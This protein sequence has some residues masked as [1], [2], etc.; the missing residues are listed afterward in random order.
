M[1]V[2]PSKVDWWLA[3][4]LALAPLISLGVGIFVLTFHRAG[5]YMAIGSS[6]FTALV[7]A[8][9]VFP[10]RYT[11]GETSLDI[12][13]GIVHRV[14]PYADIIGAE[15]SS[16]PLSAPALSLQRVKVTTQ[17]GFQLISPIDRAAFIEALNAKVKAAKV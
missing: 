14:I 6:V 17:K 4:C 13:C 16:N 1:D 3:A 9:L 8:L 12:R 5:G 10:C 11:L 7:I 15:P 2:Y